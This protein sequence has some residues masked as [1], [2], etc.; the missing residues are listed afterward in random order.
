MM[1]MIFDIR[2]DVSFALKS[3]AAPAAQG[4]QPEF[5]ALFTETL[6]AVVADAKLTELE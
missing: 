5:A 3:E 4:G 6:E 1:E 2:E